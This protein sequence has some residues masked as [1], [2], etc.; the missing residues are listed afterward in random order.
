[1]SPTDPELALAIAAALEEL[2]RTGE[3]STGSIYGF[4]RAFGVDGVERILEACEAR[5]VE[6]GLPRHGF[7]RGPDMR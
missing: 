3:L 4:G 2:D 7:I 5:R 1:M 6:L